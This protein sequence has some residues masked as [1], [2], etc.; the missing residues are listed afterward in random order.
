MK[1]GFDATSAGS[2]DMEEK[3]NSDEV[4]A[5]AREHVPAVSD[6]DLLPVTPAYE[7]KGKLLSLPPS[8][9]VRNDAVL[10]DPSIAFQ[11]I[12]TSTLFRVEG[13]RFSG[14]KTIGIYSK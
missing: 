4:I 5:W 1:K 10:S 2:G 8:W 12:E 9:D 3:G 14:L 7:Y 13:C 6:S 11:V